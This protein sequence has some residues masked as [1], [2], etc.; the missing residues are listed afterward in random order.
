M[1][2]TEAARRLMEGA[3]T[4]EE[5]EALRKLLEHQSRVSHAR[6]VELFV[7]GLAH[8]HGAF[9]DDVKQFKKQLHMDAGLLVVKSVVCALLLLG[10]YLVL[11]GVFT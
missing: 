3:E 8:I 1:D 11:A 6:S 4:P 2:E 7:Q 9:R 10:V 5:R